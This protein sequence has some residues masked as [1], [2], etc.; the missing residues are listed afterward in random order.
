M[1]T[2]RTPE[3]EAKFL[4]ALADTCNVRE[5]CK[6]AG[7]A[8]NSAYLWRRDEPDFRKK[9]EEAVEV[10][11]DALEEEAVRRAREGVD[12]A[13]YYKGDICGT[14]RKYSDTLLIFLL[15]GAKP[16]KYGDKVALTGGDKPLAIEFRSIVDE[17]K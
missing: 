14:V 11:A 17:D 3:K 6:A 15:K 7:I 9:W 4:E 2:I 16:K 5:A 10:G 13:V 12:E 1:E 8:R